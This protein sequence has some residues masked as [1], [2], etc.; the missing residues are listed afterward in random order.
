MQ[1]T[2]HGS[3]GQGKSGKVRECKSTRL[4]K[5][6]KVQKKILTVLCR[7]HTMVQIFIVNLSHCSCF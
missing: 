7:L 4:H 6:R 3:Y 2:L 5:L 1:Y